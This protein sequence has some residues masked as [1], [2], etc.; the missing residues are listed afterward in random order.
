MDRREHFDKHSTVLGELGA[1]SA[2]H[3]FQNAVAS[4]Y[5]SDKGGKQIGR[6]IA[7]RYAN[8]NSK[9]LKN[10]GSE[11]KAGIMNAAAPEKGILKDHLSEVVK[12]LP[13]FSYKERALLQALGKGKFRKALYSKALEDSP[14]VKSLLKR[15]GIPIDE[16]EKIRKILP[17]SQVDDFLKEEEV[18]HQQTPLGKFLSSATDE[19]SNLKLNKL[20]EISKHNKPE[21]LG[22]LG[23]NTGLVATEPI[24]AGLN[25]FKRWVSSPAKGR[26][27][28]IK[29]KFQRASTKFFVK[30]TFKRA[31]N[32]AEKGKRFSNL[33]SFKATKYGGNPVIAEAANYLNRT[34]IN[35]KRHFGDITFLHKM[36]DRL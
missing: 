19:L 9:K 6:E 3:V 14:H 2:T 35:A 11:A 16:I 30:P 26:L 29:E 7:L 13:E 5:L 36:V 22:E 28:K 24:S 27:G 23:A 20:R 15:H 31:L 4:K 32:L 17:K 1:I 18:I 34:A 33:L 12:E 8:K 21:I 25:G 10:L